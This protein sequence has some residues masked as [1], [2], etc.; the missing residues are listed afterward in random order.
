[1]SFF[2]FYVYFQFHLRKIAQLKDRYGDRPFYYQ[3]GPPL[4]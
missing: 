4:S 1:M 2:F 3:G